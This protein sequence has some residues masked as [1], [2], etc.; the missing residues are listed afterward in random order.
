[1]KKVDFEYDIVEHEKFFYG[2]LSE[3]QKRM[4]AGLKAMEAGYY[5]VREVA[6]RLGIHINT[7]RRGKNELLKKIVP[8]A[9]KVRQKG[10]GR[11]KTV[12]TQAASGSLK[13]GEISKIPK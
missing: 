11:K 6:K 1:M 8:P 5:G 10:G 2:Q 13:M 9:S 4:Y 7:I 12:A 3:Q